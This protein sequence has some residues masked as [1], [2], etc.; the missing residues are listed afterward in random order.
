[1]TS[2]RPIRAPGPAGAQVAERKPRVPSIRFRVGRGAFV[3]PPLGV[4]LL[5]LLGPVV[6]LTLYSFNLRTNIPGDPTAFSSFNWKDFL[7]GAGNPFRGRFFYSMKITLLVSVA[8]TAAAY[9]LAYYLAFVA[10]RFRYTLLLLLIAPFFTSYLLRV[11]A[12]SDV[13]LT[14]NGVVNQILWALRLR[15]HGDGVS[16]LLYSNFSVF[17]ILFYSWI[18]FV[19]LPIFA[20]L[21]N[22][23]HRLIEAAT[24]LGAG[25]LSTFWRVTFPLSLPGV[26]AAFVFVLIPTT[27]EFIAPLYVGGPRNQ[28]FGN[29]IQS[30]F[31]DSPNWNYGAVLALAL[32][33]VVLVLMLVFG[34]FL[35]TDLRRQGAEVGP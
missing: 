28:L 14:N 8:A 33:A 7:T 29:V 3:I 24:D 15:P 23:D 30:F 10:R 4:V 1:L 2:R 26:I 18:P 6:V 27:G 25:R 21:E 17:L 19:S 13:M 35:N 20:V 5:L 16:W 32:I 34:R 31:G 9:P 11:V 12:W 22:M